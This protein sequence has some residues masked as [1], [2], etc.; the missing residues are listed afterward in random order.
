MKAEGY[1]ITYRH[2]QRILKTLNLRRKG[3]KENI[4]EIIKCIINELEGSGSC[5]GYKTLWLRLKLKFG[6]DVY[7]DTVLELLHVSRIRSRRN[8]RESKVSPKKKRV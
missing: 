2:L 4:L 6:L 8:R 1:N 5:L 7:R 3:I